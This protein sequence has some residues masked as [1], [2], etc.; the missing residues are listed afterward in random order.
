MLA[1]GC[2]QVIGG[3]AGGGG[4]GGAAAPAPYARPGDWVCSCGNTNFAWREECHKCRAP[5]SADAQVR[6][7]GAAPAGQPWNT[8]SLALVQG[9]LGG[10]GEGRALSGTWSSQ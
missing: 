1:L 5:R 10:E 3:G 7:G 8:Q 6:V 4:G 9:Q 2:M